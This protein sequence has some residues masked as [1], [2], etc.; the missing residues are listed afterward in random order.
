MPGQRGIGARRARGSWAVRIAGTAGV[1]VAAATAASVI[2][3]SQPAARA[4]RQVPAP[5]PSRVIN[6]LTIKLVN[7]GPPTR[8]DSRPFPEKLYLSATGLAFTASGPASPADEWTAD[9]MSGGAYILIYVPNRLC[10]TAPDSPGNPTATL[11]RCD[12]SLSQRWR[13]QFLGKD[14]AG[15]NTWQLRSDADGL[16]LTAVAPPLGGQPGESGVSLTGCSS[17]ATWRQIISFR[18]AY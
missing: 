9:Q 10:L 5:L 4:R 6:V 2:I 8:A 13:H 11:A 3:V 17:P 16:C 15:R 14:A 1:L 12:L 7:P 18:P